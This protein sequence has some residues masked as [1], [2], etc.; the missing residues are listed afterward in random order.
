MAM[1]MVCSS[2]GMEAMISWV[3]CETLTVRGWSA[4]AWEGA[5]V[6]TVVSSEAMI[7]GEIW[8]MTC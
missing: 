4:L 1:D 2:R 7:R 3:F 8:T 6:L 5:Q